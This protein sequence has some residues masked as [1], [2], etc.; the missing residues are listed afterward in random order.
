MCIITCIKKLNVYTE[1]PNLI[2]N[3]FYF[4]P[5][6]VTILHQAELQMDKDKETHP[7]H[8]THRLPSHVMLVTDYKETTG[9]CAR[10]MVNGQVVC[11][12]VYLKVI[13][14]VVVHIRDSGYQ[15]SS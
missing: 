10:V 1:V 13:R 6:L 3:A 7:T 8:V 2:A 11:H 9:W 4:Q 5:S 14:I 12:R 15:Y